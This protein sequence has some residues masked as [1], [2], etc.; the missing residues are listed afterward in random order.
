MVEPIKSIRTDNPNDFTAGV[1]HSQ[2]KEI[3]RIAAAAAAAAIDI[4]I[5]EV[6]V[7]VARTVPRTRIR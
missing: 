1:S 2:R 5:T 3:I 6:I 7:S 4:V